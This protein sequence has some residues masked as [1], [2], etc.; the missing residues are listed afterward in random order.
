MSPSTSIPA[1]WRVVE[2]DGDSSYRY[3]LETVNDEIPDRLVV[4]I[5]K[6][7]STA[8]HEK[9]DPTVRH[10]QAW[11]EEAGYGRLCF[12]NLF[13]RRSSQPRDIEFGPG[14]EELPVELAVGAQNDQALRRAATR[15]EVLV[16]AWGGDA[17]LTLRS[18]YRTMISEVLDLL[19]DASL[20]TMGDVAAS[21][22]PV[23]G[24][25]WSGLRRGRELVPADLDR[26]DPRR[27]TH[28]P[29]RDGRR[30]VLPA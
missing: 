7:P 26:L 11:A 12:V 16:A 15:A 13:A 30:P 10:V 5:G 25:N 24:Y 2:H 1:P 22:Y 19:S 27:W 6:N 18:R 9:D 20:Q 17:K 28:R 21:G 4:V 8:D 29:K 14:T 23:H 3:V